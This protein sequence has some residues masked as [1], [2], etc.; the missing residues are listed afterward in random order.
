MGIP[1]VG[2]PAM[3]NNTPWKTYN[4]LDITV[5]GHGNFHVDVGPV[6]M[7]DAV[8]DRLRLR[9]ENEK[10][11]DAKATKIELDC[12][13]LLGHDDG[14]ADYIVR[15]CKIVGLNRSDSTFKFK[16][17][18]DGSVDAHLVQYVLP[19]T[20][21]N[22]LLLEELAVTKSIVRDIQTSIKNRVLHQNRWGGRIDPSKYQ[23][24]LDNLKANYE[25]SLK[26]VE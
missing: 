18:E 25:R 3:V 1:G 13:V 24:K 22:C 26:G 2:V 14:G 15:R 20:P 23:G 16:Q 7:Y 21:K 8:W 12:V 9:I 5:D 19:N 6:H 4:G 11:A 17:T 10:K